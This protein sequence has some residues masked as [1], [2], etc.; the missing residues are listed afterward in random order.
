MLNAEV[1]AIIM[2]TQLYNRVSQDAFVRL[3]LYGSKD[4]RTVLRGLSAGNRAWL[5]G[6]DSLTKPGGLFDWGREVDN[7][8]SVGLDNNHEKICC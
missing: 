8:S 6:V 7:F 3:E 4:P 2:Q 1:L 5:P